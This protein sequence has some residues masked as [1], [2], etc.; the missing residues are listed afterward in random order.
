MEFIYK[1]IW[2]IIINLFYIIN[3]WRKDEYDV[4]KIVIFKWNLWEIF[5]DRRW[6]ICDMK[7]CIGKLIVG[8]RL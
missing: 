5:R 6:N 2:V 1:V 4:E 3:N 8:C 7:V